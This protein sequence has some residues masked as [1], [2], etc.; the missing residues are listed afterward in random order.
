MEQ[1]G[2][3]DSTAGLLAKDKSTKV[4]VRPHVAVNVLSQSLFMVSFMSEIN[5]GSIR[6]HYLCIT[7][8]LSKLTKVPEQ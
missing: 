2:S 4:V 1:P 5:F 8:D 6:E 7:Q 3:L